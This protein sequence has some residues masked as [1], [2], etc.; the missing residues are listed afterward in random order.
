MAPWSASLRQ[1]I[2][3]ECWRPSF[4]RYLPPRFSSLRHD[5][6]GYLCFYNIDASHNGRLTG[7]QIPGGHRRRLIL[8]RVAIDPANG[9]GR[10][11]AQAVDSS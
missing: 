3:D 2:L 5:H 11:Y 8:D 6:E 9:K 7:G 4:A 10:G 1:R